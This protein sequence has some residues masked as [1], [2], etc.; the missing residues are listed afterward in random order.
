MQGVQL[1]GQTV[2]VFSPFQRDG[3][4]Q[5]GPCA[6]GMEVGNWLC[7]YLDGNACLGIAP[8]AR[9]SHP[10]AEAA[11]A[12]DLDPVAGVYGAGHGIAN[13]LQDNFG[14][15]L[16]E[17]GHLSNL[18]DQ[19]QSGQARPRRFIHRSKGSRLSL[20]RFHCATSAFRW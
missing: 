17:F 4:D 2:G 8:Q 12:A 13:R 1:A 11:K 7:G 20:G 10:A 18:F 3:I 14:I 19:I 16:G 9:P 15:L 6:T 5:R